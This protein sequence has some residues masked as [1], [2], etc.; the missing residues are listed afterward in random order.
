MGENVIHRLFP[1]R[2]LKLVIPCLVLLLLY[3]LAARPGGVVVERVEVPLP[4]LPAVGAEEKEG[5]EVARVRT[6]R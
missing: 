3:G 2:V 1:R 4:G 6:G 5:G